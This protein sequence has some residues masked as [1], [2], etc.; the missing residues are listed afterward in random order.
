MPSYMK[1]TRPVLKIFKMDGYFPEILRTFGEL[2]Q[3][4]RGKFVPL[5]DMKA[6]DDLTVQLSAFLNSAL[7]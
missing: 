3:Y 2:G 6:S 7:D 4:V 5:H 1:A